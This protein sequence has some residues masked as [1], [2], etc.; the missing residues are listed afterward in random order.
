MNTQ[1]SSMIDRIKN[2]YFFRYNEQ[3]TKKLLSEIDFPVQYIF[4]CGNRIIFVKAKGDTIVVTDEAYE[5]KGRYVFK[6]LSPVSVFTRFNEQYIAFDFEGDRTYLLSSDF[7]PLGKLNECIPFF[8]NKEITAAVQDA[9]GG[10]YAAERNTGKLY[11][12]AADGTESV[13]QGDFSLVVFMDIVKGTLYF[14]DY[15]VS[16]IYGR[17]NNLHFFKNGTIQALPVTGETIA[18][19]SKLDCYFVS[20]M[21][22]ENVIRKYT[23]DNELVFEN[24][25]YYGAKKIMPFSLQVNG[26]HLLILDCLTYKPVVFDIY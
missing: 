14:F 17:S 2:N 3:A 25:C 1:L 13:Y 26:N 6:E 4:K 9:E 20:S 15:V 19:S 23:A 10:L 7:A 22:V 12:L 24:H 11:H 5:L 16:L 8:K 18:Y 21:S